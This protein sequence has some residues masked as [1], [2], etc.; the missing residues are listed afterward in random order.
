MPA[1]KERIFREWCRRKAK[2]FLEAV[3]LV[4]FTSY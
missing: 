4:N 1:I 3:G 2:R